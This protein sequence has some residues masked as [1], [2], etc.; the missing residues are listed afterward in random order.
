MDITRYI[1]RKFESLLMLGGFGKRREDR[2]AAP[3]RQCQFGHL[4][5]SGARLCSYGHRPV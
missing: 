4:V 1:Q 2:P 5:S 3:A